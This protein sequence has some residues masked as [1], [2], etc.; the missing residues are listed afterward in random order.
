MRLGARASS[1]TPIAA[2]ASSPATRAARRFAPRATRD[3]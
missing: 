2:R 3:A 1:A